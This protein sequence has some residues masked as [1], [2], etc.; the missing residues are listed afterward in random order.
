MNSIWIAVLESKNDYDNFTV[1]AFTSIEEFQEKLPAMIK[2]GFAEGLWFEFFLLKE[3]PLNSFGNSFNTKEYRYDK[4]GKLAHVTG[5]EISNG[6]VTGI[7]ED[8]IK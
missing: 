8:S 2:E 4:G 3:Y 1:G 6:R 7:T 5:Y